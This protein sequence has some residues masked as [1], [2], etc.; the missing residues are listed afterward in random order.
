MWICEYHRIL[1]Y[2]AFIWLSR[3]SGCLADSGLHQKLFICQCGALL[4]I[5]KT[6]INPSRTK[7]LFYYGD[8]FVVLKVCFLSTQN[9]EQHRNRW[10]CS[11]LEPARK[12]KSKVNCFWSIY[13]RYTNNIYYHCFCRKFICFVSREGEIIVLLAKFQIIKKKNSCSV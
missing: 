5:T 8:S 2:K 1:L 4:R 3:L 9:F 13:C 6:H 7:K 11:F 10:L 12:G